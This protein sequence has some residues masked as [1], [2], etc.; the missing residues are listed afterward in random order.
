MTLKALVNRTIVLSVIQ[1]K[2]IKGGTDDGA[3]N[4]EIIITDDLDAM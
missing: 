3:S 1:S 4:T 2:K